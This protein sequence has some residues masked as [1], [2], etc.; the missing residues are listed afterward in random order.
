[1]RRAS[2]PD[3]ELLELRQIAANLQHLLCLNSSR[4]EDAAGDPAGVAAAQSLLLLLESLQRIP[5]T[6]Q[7]LQQSQ[8]TA[9]VR[10]CCQVRDHASLLLAVDAAIVICA[11]G[12]LQQS[13][14][15]KE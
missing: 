11:R 5:I 13:Y 7:L 10:A 9:C 8:I 2:V 12:S 15:H 1:M 6:A 4:G 3:L 14:L